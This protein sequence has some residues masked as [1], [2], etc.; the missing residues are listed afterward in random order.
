MNPQHRRRGDLQIR[1]CR[2]PLKLH[3][4]ITMITSEQGTGELHH[5]NYRI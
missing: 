1:I 3:A 5:R 2:H 4:N